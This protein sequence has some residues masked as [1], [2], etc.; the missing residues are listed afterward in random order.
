M[1]D[2]LPDGLR[3]VDVGEH[4]LKGLARSERVSQLIGPDLQAEFPPLRTL[5]TRGHQLPLER[6]PLI[7]RSREV[8]AIGGSYS[9]TMSDW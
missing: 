6:G 1:Q 9:G 8:A 3:L 4:Q 7:G 5:E 2:A